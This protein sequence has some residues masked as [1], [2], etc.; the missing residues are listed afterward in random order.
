MSHII[1]TVKFPD[2]RVSQKLKDETTKA[3]G[4]EQENIS[5]Y[6]RKAVEQRNKRILKV[7]E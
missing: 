3:A 6:I 5:E 1:K 7:R 2:V 4:I